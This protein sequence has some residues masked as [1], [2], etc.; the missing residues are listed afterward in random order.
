[1]KEKKSGKEPKR[2][3]KGGK[4]PKEKQKHINNRIRRKEKRSRS[5][6]GAKAP[7]GP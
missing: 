4:E 5:S 6:C 2:R 1:M 7:V 3:Y